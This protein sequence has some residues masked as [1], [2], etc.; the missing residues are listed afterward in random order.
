MA[1]SVLVAQDLGDAVGFSLAVLAMVA[2]YLADDRALE[3]LDALTEA[4]EVARGFEDPEIAQ[5]LH[6]TA[7]S[8][9]RHLGIL[10][11]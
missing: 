10:A 4:R 3:A 7:E 11:K 9:L 8:L 2:F 1:E 5:R 6:N